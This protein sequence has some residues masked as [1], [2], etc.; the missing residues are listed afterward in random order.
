M[1]GHGTLHNLR[2][3][4]DGLVA[5]VKISGLSPAMVDAVIEHQRVE[6]SAIDK[7]PP[8]AGADRAVE[9]VQAAQAATRTETG[10]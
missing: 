5:E 8:M 1:L 2:L 3:T 6:L 9:L 7:A 10:H 4:D